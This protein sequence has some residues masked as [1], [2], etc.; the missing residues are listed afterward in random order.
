METVLTIQ[1]AHATVDLHE[2]KKSG[3]KVDMT[4]EGQASKRRRIEISVIPRVHTYRAVEVMSSLV[5]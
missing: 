4:T 5:H 3:F 1:Q 2:P